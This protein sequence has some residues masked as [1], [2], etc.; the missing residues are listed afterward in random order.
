[1]NIELATEKMKGYCA[2]QERCHKEVKEKLIKLEVYRDDAD[3]IIITL[4]QEN[5]LNEERYAE[6]Y[7]SGKFR[8][9][10]WGRNKIKMNLKQK[11]I[12]DYCI[13]K[14]LK[15]ID[16]NE[17]L[18]TILYWVNRLSDK[19]TGYSD[20]AKKGKIAHYLM[21]KGFESSLIWEQLND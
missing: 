18:E 4:I 11:G 21:L 12:S 7:C 16:E 8:I 10:R 2:Y 1:M 3:E 19:Y 5:F 14:G 15:E 20:Y 9:K 17:Y 6:A 13:I